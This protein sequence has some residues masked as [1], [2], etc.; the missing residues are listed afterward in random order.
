MLR[1][2]LFVVRR[3]KG[4]IEIGQIVWRQA[5]VERATVLANM[6]RLA[7]LRYRT[8]AVLAQHPGQR[9]LCRGCAET[10][11]N[12]LECDMTQHT[13]LLDRRIGHNGDAAALAPWQELELD[14]ATLEIVEHLIGRNVRAV[15]QVDQLL[16]VADIEIADAPVSDLAST[17]QTF[18]G[19][20]GLFQRNESPPMQQIEIDLMHPEPGQTSVASRYRAVSVGVLR[21][22]LA[23]QKDF[24]APSLD[25]LADKPFSATVGVHF[26]RVDQAHAEIDAEA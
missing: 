14:A 11:R 8:Y 21:Q 13:A 26:G 19:I 18:E 2:W 6:L 7:R 4:F 16:H 5:N 20:D 24:V 17:H 25:G 10:R 9:H 1:Q 3:R 15:E 12:R 22:H 23:H